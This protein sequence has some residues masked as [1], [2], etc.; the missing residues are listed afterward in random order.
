MSLDSFKAKKTLHVGNK[1]YQYFSLPEAQ[2]LGDVSRLPVTLKI[3][4]ENLLRFE[5]DQTVK[6]HDIKSLADWAN[7]PPAYP[8]TKHDVHCQS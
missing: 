5:D 1:H 3:L 6:A 4:L 2:G 8:H 7:N